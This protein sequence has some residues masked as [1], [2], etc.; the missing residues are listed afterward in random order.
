M[1]NRFHLFHGRVSGESR[2]KTSKV[3]GLVFSALT[4]RS[5]IPRLTDLALYPLIVY[6]PKGII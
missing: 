6:S 5:D 3:L 2:P 1:E 4:L